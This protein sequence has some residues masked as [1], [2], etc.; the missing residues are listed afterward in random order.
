LSAQPDDDEADA[1]EVRERDREE[2][3]NPDAP[4]RLRR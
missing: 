4:R 1:I 2:P 3:L